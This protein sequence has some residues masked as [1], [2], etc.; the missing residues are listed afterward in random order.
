QSDAGTMRPSRA[1]TST[2]SAGG[3]RATAGARTAGSE[4]VIWR[5]REPDGARPGT[6]SSHRSWGRASFSPIAAIQ[7]PSGIHSTARQ[8]PGHG[9][10]GRE[11]AGRDEAEAGRDEAEAGRDEAEAGRDEAA[12]LAGSAR[13]PRRP[14]PS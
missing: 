2:R 8:T 10:T 13:R 3:K 9:W 4:R 6:G 5:A 14:G 1:V 11:A 12:A 7:R